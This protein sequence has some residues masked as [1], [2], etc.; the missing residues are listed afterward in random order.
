MDI[1]GL[2]PV[3]EYM[4]DANTRKLSTKDGSQDD[5]VDYFNECGGGVLCSGL[6]ERRALEKKFFETH[7][8]NL[9]GFDKKINQIILDGL[10][11]FRNYEA[12]TKKFSSLDNGGINEVYCEYVDGRFAV[13][14]KNGD[15]DVKLYGPD[16]TEYTPEEYEYIW[17]ETGKEIT[18][19]ESQ[20]YNPQDNSISFAMG[21]TYQ[22]GGGRVLTIGSTSVR[23]KGQRDDIYDPLAKGLYK[24][25]LCAE[26][27]YDTGAIPEEER[28]A[29]LGFLR[30]MGINTRKNFVV[31]GAEFYVPQGSNSIV[32]AG[33]KSII[34]NGFPLSLYKK[35]RARY[36]AW[37]MAPLKEN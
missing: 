36:E 23:I 8:V 16:Q 20:P 3:R 12:G 22:A 6:T 33:K 30:R 29:V 14:F 34:E 18:T 1:S 28:E 26:Q 2:N 4:F 9:T 7:D 21:D 19:T 5:L 37:L 35:A 31:N 27:K 32:V 13:T 10:I 11:T 24:F 25:I 17:S 15:K